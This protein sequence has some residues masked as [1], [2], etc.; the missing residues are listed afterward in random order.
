MLALALGLWRSTRGA[1]T[2]PAVAGRAVEPS[3]A[4]AQPQAGEPPPVTA[5]PVASR[6]R[7]RAP[8]PSERPPELAPEAPK[9]QQELKRDANGKLVP[10]IYI[11]D[12]RAQVPTLEAPMKA[13]IARHAA[14]ATGKAVLSFIVAAKN[15]KLVIETTGVQDEDTLAAYPDL[16]ACMHKTASLL[17]VD[18]H[19]IP[20][21]G[22]AIYV[23]RHV[24]I[25]N[26]E[27]LENSMFD[28]SYSH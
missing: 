12:L 8:R 17:V 18:D 9:V 22:T 26:G 25:E 21:L 10:I 4:P 16:L 3:A 19:P 13:C 7:P 28:F 27:L 23:R 6:A 5:G 15:G 2:T 11:A 1:T 20:E 14:G 24:R